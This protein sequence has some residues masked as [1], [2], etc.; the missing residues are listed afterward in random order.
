MHFNDPDVVRDLEYGFN[1]SAT[2]SSKLRAIRQ[3]QIRTKVEENLASSAAARSS[4]NFDVHLARADQEQ[5]GYSAD[6]WTMSDLSKGE[7]VFGGLPG[8]SAYYTT[9]TTVVDS[10]G[11]RSELFQSLQVKQHPEFGYRPKIGEYVVLRDISIPEGNALANP[12]FGTGGGQQYFIRNYKRDL[13]LI[14]EIPLDP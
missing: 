3:D 6:N 2:D 10:L 11:G 13:E 14:R 4:S 9:A 12:Q 7:T 1:K 5:W 8:Q